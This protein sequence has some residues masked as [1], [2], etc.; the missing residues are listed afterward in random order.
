[1]EVGV[2]QVV[3]LQALFV[4]ALQYRPGVGPLLDLADLDRDLGV[5]AALLLFLFG[6]VLHA[7]GRHDVLEAGV[8]GVAAVLLH[9]LPGHAHRQF[10]LGLLQ[11]RYFR[12][13]LCDFVHEVYVDLVVL[14]AVEFHQLA[15]QFDESGEVDLVLLLAVGLLLPQDR[16][17][18]LLGEAVAFL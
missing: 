14:L 4:V 9:D 6:V 18:E 13:E 11:Q 7:R 1:M 15:I 3:V 17:D 5:L 8:D 10:L 2:H 16:V 12:G